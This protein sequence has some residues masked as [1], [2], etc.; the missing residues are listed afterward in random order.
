MPPSESDGSPGPQSDQTLPV[1]SSGDRQIRLGKN[2]LNLG[3]AVIV[4]DE[5]GKIILLNP[6]AEILTGW[7]DDEAKDRP[8]EA[9]FRI[10]NEVTR[11]PVIQP[12]HGVIDQGNIHRLPQLT[13]L[14][15]KDG[16]ELSIDDSASPI[17]NAS[18]GIEGVI[19]IFRDITEH[20]KMI[21]QD[22]DSRHRGEVIIAAVQ[23]PM[24]VLDRN[25]CIR[26]ANHSFYEVFKTTSEA[27][28]G[29]SLLDI[30]HG[31]WNNEEVVSIL[32]DTLSSATDPGELVL[33][34]EF[35]AI[36][37]RIM[38]LNVR[39]LLVKGAKEPILLLAIEDITERTRLQ[40][41]FE[42]SELRYR[43]LFETAKDGILILNGETG[44]IT[45]VNPFLRDLLGL[46][47]EEMAGK[48]LWEIGLLGNEE[49]SQ[50]SFRELQEKGYV[51][52]DS[53]P[54][55]TPNGR[56]IEVEIVSNIYRSN[57]QIVIQCNIRDTTEQKMAAQ[58]LRKAKEAAEDAS[59]AKDLFLSMLSHELR[60]PLTPVLATVAY[61]ESMP[62]L[63]R[64][65]REEFATIRRNVELEA[66]LIDDL[67]D[68]NRIAQNKLEIFLEAVDAHAAIRTALETCHAD[69]EA[70]K[71]EVSLALRADGR[72]I[73][74]DPTRLQQILWNLLKNAVK[75]TPVEG[76][77]RI[78]TQDSPTGRL[79]IEVADTGEGINSDFLPR[80]FDVFEQG[81]RDA[82]RKLGGLG[83]GLSIAKMLVDLQGGSLTAI[84]EGE[85][86][87]STFRIELDQAPEEENG[88]THP[89]QDR[90]PSPAPPPIVSPRSI[91][92][93]LVEDNPD[94]LR[95][96]SLLL[97]SVGYI[98][99]TATNVT[100]AVAV[101]ATDTFQL[102]I[103][104]IG[105]PDGSG[106][107]IMRSCRDTIGLKGIAF[108]GYASAEDQ[109]ESK[110]AG[111]SHH[112]SKPLS[113]NNLIDVIKQ[114][115]A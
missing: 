112:L 3:D 28:L 99:K 106:L 83:L 8:I 64:K 48:Q 42:E 56:L 16:S 4:T 89:G 94:T 62:D 67:L 71:L 13:L 21:Q 78:R 55:S 50:A 74:A 114:T 96:I 33:E 98:V 81:N 75:F 84:S 19:L 77:I 6:E 11:L 20:R 61:I 46:S 23:H 91:K 108:S 76:S 37:P 109:Y 45:D 51:R 68:L 73:W 93:L 111:F 54:F 5:H 17:P 22:E 80:I 65:V 31:Q 105:L 29:H 88:E 69:I 43:K 82:A 39:K 36:G 35:E 49:E 72:H 26:T 18:G 32:K 104:D 24:A 44:T 34:C 107:E 97:K 103:S 87:G 102:L 101:L 15:A 113:I 100:E 66:R 63:P 52:Y 110:S 30:G 59:R 115:V 1:E 92:V 58:A 7:S 40:R 60:T 57:D 2:L 41:S 85:G 38:H 12:V 95:A 90:D 79:I 27:T 9:I 86:L 10:I 25:F 70:K 47:W 53:L 14:I